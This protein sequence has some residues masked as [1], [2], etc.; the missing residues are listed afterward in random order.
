MK[1]QGYALPWDKPAYVDGLVESVA[2][3][4]V[5]ADTP[6]N[7][8]LLFGDHATDGR[9][10]FAQTR[11]GSLRLWSDDYGLAFSAT[12]DTSRATA[13][14]AARSIAAADV[15]QC[16]VNFTGMRR[17]E[18]GRVIW[19]AIDHIALVWSG[20]YADTGCWMEDQLIR[21]RAPELREM[22]MTYA[23]TVMARARKPYAWGASDKGAAAGSGPRHAPSLPPPRPDLA[24]FANQMLLANRREGLGEFNGRPIG[25]AIKQFLANC[26]A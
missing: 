21:D 25:M 6:R 1:V 12:L 17:R 23:D 8:T 11:D 10:V 4:A 2:P 9:E 20:A 26:T 5:A 13:R 14:A 15:S 24:A 19:G 22:S 7:I 18:D 3:N 16:S